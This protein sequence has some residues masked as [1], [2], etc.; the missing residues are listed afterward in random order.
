METLQIKLEE[1]KPFD[2]NPRYIRDDKFEQLIQSILVFPKMLEL[3]PIVID[4]NT[5]LGG[6][7]RY[8]ALC[9][10]QKMDM[11]AI[12][13]NVKK[14]AKFNRLSLAEQNRLMDYWSDW[15][16]AP[17]API[18]K[19]DNLSEDE[20]REF[21]IKDNNSFGQ[22]D[23]D[24]LAN[25]FDDLDLS[26]WGMDLPT[27]WDINDREDKDDEI[28]KDKM[29]EQA[30]SDAAIREYSEDTNY[31]L[32]KL[33]RFRINKKITD[34]IT[35]GIKIGTIRPEIAEILKIRA[36]QCTIFNFDEIIKYYR[37]QDATETEKKLLLGLYMVFVAPKELVEKGL[38]QIKELS[39]KIYDYE[40]ITNEN[41]ES[42]EY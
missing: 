2:K 35:K 42:E 32:T 28:D 39:N 25:E 18:L 3:R 37:S 6:N 34:E 8:R 21:V 33:Y 4:K 11:H 15:L 10:I 13:N 19:A 36:L 26:E 17:Y 20:K 16:K 24:M 22:W 12:R 14:S 9:A 7:M 41:G 31:D 30:S 23:W 29:I 40:Y 1:I 27:D 38:M 5:I